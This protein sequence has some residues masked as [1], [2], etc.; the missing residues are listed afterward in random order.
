MTPPTDGLA[1]LIVEEDEPPVVKPS[2]RH[3]G[4]VL[5]A[6]LEPMLVLI[7]DRKVGVVEGEGGREIERHEGLA[8]QV[9]PH[10]HDV[11]CQSKMCQ[12]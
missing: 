9:G 8:E 10:A 7:G 4:R 3:V 6:K 12:K 2:W 1:D 11:E 5:Q